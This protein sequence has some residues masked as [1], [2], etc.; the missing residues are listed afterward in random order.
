MRHISLIVWMLLFF[1]LFMSTN[2]SLDMRKAGYYRVS[3]EGAVE[4]FLCPHGCR[5]TPGKRGF[6]GVREN[7]SGELKS[8]VW[9][10]PCAV[11]VD[12]IE[13]KPLYHFLPGE[14]AYSVAAMGCNLSCRFCQNHDISQA[15][16]R[17]VSG[18]D[19]PAQKV[20]EDAVSRDCGI[21]AYTYTEPTVFLEFALECAG[22]ARRRGLANVFVTNG[23]TSRQAL[24]DIVM[25][26]DGVN[27][28]L[29]SMRD[30]AYRDYC[31]GRLRP[32]LESIK[33]YVEA[34]VWVEVTTLIVPGMNDSPAEIGEMAEFIAGLGEDIP[35]HVS[36]FH[37]D[38]EMTGVMPTEIDAVESAVSAGRKAGLSHVYPGNIGSGDGDITVCPGCGTRL[39]ERRGYR[40]GENRLSDGCC[41][42]CS[43]RLAGVF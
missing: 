32:V 41:S 17:E 29:K 22:I 16:G 11:N 35:W 27:V 4:C 39:I 3:E 42:V 26:V 19:M 5:I 38:Y 15:A 1:I 7:V 6:C 10:R 9:G 24:E 36:R 30:E 2:T 18:F 20:V 13:K 8:L 12:P 23:Y 14:R 21:I 40:V 28:D 34:G 31:G 43:R 25:A 33:K 37:P